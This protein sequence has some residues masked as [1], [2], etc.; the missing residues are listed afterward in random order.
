MKPVACH[1][2]TPARARLRPTAR[3]IV[4]IVHLLPP[5]PE[6]GKRHRGLDSTPF[7]PRTTRISVHPEGNFGLRAAR[8][9]S[10]ENPASCWPEDRRHIRQAR[11]GRRFPECKRFLTL[12][13][14]HRCGIAGH[15]VHR[16]PGHDRRRW[17]LVTPARPCGPRC[18]PPADRVLDVRVV[19]R[20][21]WPTFPRYGQ[22]LPEGTWGHRGHFLPRLSPRPRADPSLSA[23][24]ADMLTRGRDVM[25]HQRRAAGVTTSATVTDEPPQPGKK[26][27]RAVS[28]QRTGDDVRGC[29]T[30]AIPPRQ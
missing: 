20:L 3:S 4:A 10:M 14:R 7:G 23:L 1:S 29:G 2:A 22:I 13:A 9:R 15:P 26:A 17:R 19:V 30:H 25:R 27:A 11:P 28:R 24:G 5:W 12:R 18:P 16:H 21:R 8:T 6:K